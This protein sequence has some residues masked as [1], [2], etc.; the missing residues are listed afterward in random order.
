MPAAAEASECVKQIFNRFCLGGPIAKLNADASE[1]SSDGIE[2][3]YQ[4][5]DRGKYVEIAE[6]SAHIHTVMRRET[7][8]GWLNF[9]EWKTKLQRVYGRGEDLGHFPAYASSR[10]SRLNAINAGKGYAHFRWQQSGWSVSL[11]WNHR[12]YIELRYALDEHAGG[13]LDDEGL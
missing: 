9:T 10:S 4:L 1:L 12:D 11:V 8:G 6:R 5:T 3:V 2:T 13:G 7:P